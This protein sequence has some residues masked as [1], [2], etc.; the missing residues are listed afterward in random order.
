MTFREKLD[1][2]LKTLDEQR[3]EFQHLQDDKIYEFVVYRAITKLID[4][5]MSR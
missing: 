1:D 2:L 3:K 4:N 5:E